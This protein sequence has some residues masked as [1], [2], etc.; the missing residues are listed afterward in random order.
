MSYV[1]KDVLKSFTSDDNFL[2]KDPPP[3]GFDEAIAQADGIIFQYTHI[4]T[5]ATPATA[6]PLLK[7]IACA[8][9]IWFTTG[10]GSD[11]GEEEISRRKKL[12]DDA[13]DQLKEI[14]KGDL[15][16]IDAAGDAVA[17]LNQPSAVFSSTKR[18]TE[19]P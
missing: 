3:A 2:T 11:L 5:P 4:A 15:H 10:M 6:I 8:L 16:L 12:Y 13:M 19:L 7:N 14:Q 17:Q 18:L 9:V 1:D